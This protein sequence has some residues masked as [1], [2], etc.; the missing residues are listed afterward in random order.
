MT[1][2]PDRTRSWYLNHYEFSVRAFRRS[3]KRLARDDGGI[4]LVFLLL[5]DRSNTSKHLETL[6]PSQ[7]ARRR[8]LQSFN[9]LGG[10]HRTKSFR[11][12]FAY[13]CLRQIGDSELL[14]RADACRGVRRRVA[15][16]KR[17]LNM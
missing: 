5:D 16:T 6:L 13:Q 10:T 11:P 9:A 12:V 4:E 2:A 17:S 14:D 8:V 15:S 1:S 7:S 3:N